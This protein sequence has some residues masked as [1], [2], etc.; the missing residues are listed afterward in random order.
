MGIEDAP[1]NYTYLSPLITTPHCHAPSCIREEI[2]NADTGQLLFNS[3][4]RYGS[5]E[6]GETSRVFNEDSYATLTPCVFGHQPGLQ[7]PF[8]LTP[9]TNIYAVKFFNNTYRHLGQMAQVRFGP[10]GA[11][12]RSIL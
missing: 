9:D 11:F 12:I 6:F 5:P 10:V 7:T 3:T 4:A 1:E 8:R 2:Y